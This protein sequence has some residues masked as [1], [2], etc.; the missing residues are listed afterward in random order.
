V[1]ARI[2]RFYVFPAFWTVFFSAIARLE[3]KTAALVVKI[4][5]GLAFWSVFLLASLVSF[6]WLWKWL[7][8]FFLLARKFWLD[9][10]MVQFIFSLASL[11]RRKIASFYNRSKLASEA[12][13]N[14]NYVILQPL[15]KKNWAVFTTTQNLRAKIEPFSRPIKKKWAI[16]TTNQN[17]RAKKKWTIPRPAKTCEQEEKLKIFATNQNVT[18][19]ARKFWSVVKWRN[20]ASC[21][22]CSQVLIDCKMIFLLARFAH[23]SLSLTRRCPPLKLSPGVLLWI[24]SDFRKS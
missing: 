19:F 17:L 14:K 22:L 20:F 5:I 15:K 2:H 21:S 1:A 4:L 7:N 12:S 13:K 9:V 16:F 10:K 11:A 8:F 18:R 6:D 23:G 3:K 24:V